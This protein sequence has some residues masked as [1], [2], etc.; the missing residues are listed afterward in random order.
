MHMKTDLCSVVSLLCPTLRL[1]FCH[2]TS[3]WTGQVWAC[4]IALQRSACMV[5]AALA[6][7]MK[8]ASKF[9]FCQTRS[10]RLQGMFGLHSH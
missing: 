10:D 9:V 4:L 7:L 8:G 1:S 3:V 6:A 5:M 2:C